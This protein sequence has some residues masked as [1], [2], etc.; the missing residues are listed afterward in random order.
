MPML[1]TPERSHM[2]PHSAP[3]AIG[4]AYATIR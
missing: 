4:T 3:K 1:V 2:T